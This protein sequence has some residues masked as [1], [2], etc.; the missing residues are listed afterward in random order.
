MTEIKDSNINEKLKE[1]N[2]EE[3]P[4]DTL[5]NEIKKE[6]IS[7]INVKN[8]SIHEN[9][10]IKMLIDNDKENKKMEKNDIMD[11]E[12]I[13]KA[14]K[15]PE[16]IPFNEYKFND[17]IKKIKNKSIEKKMKDI[18]DSGKKN[19]N[20]KNEKD[21]DNKFIDKLKQ[22]EVKF[23]TINEYSK[24]KKNKIELFLKKNKENNNRYNNFDND[25]KNNLDENNKKS[26][27]DFNFNRKNKFEISK[28]EHKDIKQ[29]YFSTDKFYFYNCPS[30]NKKNKIESYKEEMKKIYKKYNVERIMRQNNNIASMFS[31]KDKIKK[32][33][34]KFK[35]NQYENKLKEK[36]LFN[37]SISDNDK[38]NYRYRNIT[39]LENFKTLSVEKPSKLKN[40]IEDIY[41]EINT[42]KN[43][44][45]K[46]GI[47]EKLFNVKTR[48]KYPNVQNLKNN[49]I[50]INANHLMG[51]N[52][53]TNSKFSNFDDLLKLCSKRNLK[54]L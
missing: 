44:F 26:H 4:I 6:N 7:D 12:I 11:E 15:I 27:F 21:N 10:E 53:F 51:K 38:K 40:M 8:Q 31:A 34:D 14:N 18:F 46:I 54:K 17:T 48:I 52:R 23:E 30:N 33:F 24:N 36:K 42:T 41:M 19:E 1:K 37:N 49:I 3:K 5:K 22:I 32:M 39:N 45:S 50:I 47:K 13:K 25:K 9:E 20:N 16:I 29:T 43:H 2:L 28:N 35:Q